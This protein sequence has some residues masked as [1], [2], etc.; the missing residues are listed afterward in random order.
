MPCDSALVRF[1]PDGRWLA[2]AKVPG[3]E[4]RLWQVGS[5]HPGPAIQGGS[6]MAFSRDGRFFAID[7]GGRVRLVDPDTGREVTTLDPGTGSSTGFVCLAISPDGTQV[8]AGRDHMI[9]LWDLRRIREQLAAL[10]LDWEFPPYPPPAERPPL[11]SM[12][13]VHP[14]DN[15]IKTGPI[16]GAPAELSLPATE[17]RAP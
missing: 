2:V 5:W 14:T 13:L 16:A 8:A 17:P 9:H 11:R 7:D 4:C 6:T 10:G 15:P 3:H 12:V 1:S